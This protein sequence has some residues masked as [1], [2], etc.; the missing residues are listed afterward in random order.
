MKEGVC[1][2]PFHGD[3]VITLKEYRYPIRSW[4]RE[5]LGGLI[6]LGETP[7]ES[8][9]RELLEETGYEAEVLNLEEIPVEELKYMIAS[10][11]FMHGAGLAAWAKHC[12][13]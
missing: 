2:L 6:D 3:K 9:K 7:E 4:Q 1:I 13:R 12:C 10:G 5:L 8:A 11:E